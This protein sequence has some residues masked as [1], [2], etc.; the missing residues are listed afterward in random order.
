MPV[1]LKKL[2]GVHVPYHKNTAALESTRMP[3]PDVVTIAMQQHLGAPCTPTVA[4]GDTVEVGQLLGDNAQA[5]LSSPVYSSVSGKVTGIVDIIT[6][7]GATVKAVQ[8]ET[9]KAQKV[10]AEVKAPTVT[11]H[12]EFVAAIRKCGL[13]GM[14]GAGFPTNI[15]LDPKN[16]DE[17][18]T[19]I[20][21]GAECEPYITCDTRLMLENPKGI[22]EGVDLV[23]KYLGIKKIVI[24]IESNK[25]EAIASMK[26][27]AQGHEGV[28][29]LTLRAMYPKGAE[30]VVI[31]EAT[32]RTV[33]EG[34]LP[35]DVGTLVLNVAT[36]A[37]IADYMRT[38]MPVVEKLITVDGSA[39]KE[40]KNLIVPIGT[41]IQDIL[42]YCGT[43]CEPRKILMGGPMMGVAVLDVA[44]PILKN[45]NAILAFDE[46]DS[47]TGEETA[48][49]RC[50]RCLRACPFSLAPAALDRAYHAGDTDALQMLKVNIC[51]ECGC[52]AYVCPAKRHLV[53]YNKMGKLLVRQAAQLK[54]SQEVG[55]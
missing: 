47:R 51:M 20:I 46:K 7:T 38:G 39:V 25:P 37:K 9:D 45:N 42:D 31:Y 8:I 49:I 3:I 15:K 29:V 1:F 12:K 41:H 21:N 52:C 22:L 4:A 13:V 2:S 34:K 10:S 24:A 40:P 17:V 14:G 5:F 55:K 44:Y 33:P 48:C 54:K 26:E 43:K 18:D 36:C 32:G 19:L 16:L 35:A 11:N 53:Q 6:A 28:S 50:G 23:S 27:A 30:K